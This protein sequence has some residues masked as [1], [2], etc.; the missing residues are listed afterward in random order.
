MRTSPP[1][2][3]FS[4]AALLCAAAAHGQSNL[5]PSLFT[6]SDRAQELIQ[7]PSVDTLDSR[8]DT[9]HVFTRVDVMPEPMEELFQGCAKVPPTGSALEDECLLHTKVYVRFIVERDGSV[10][11]PA[12]VRSACPTLDK[13]ALGCV[14]HMRPLQPG[15]LKGVPVRVQMVIPM[16]FEPR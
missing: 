8:V 12:V 9:M 1:L 2:L 11:S 16:Q 14:E 7:G 4:L 5:P 6:S 15:K 3:L 13:M 10:S